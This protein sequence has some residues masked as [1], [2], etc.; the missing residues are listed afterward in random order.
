[1]EFKNIKPHN[2]LQPYIEKMWV[3]KSSG[4]LP[5]EDLKLVV[6]NGNIKLTY[7]FIN[8]IKAYVNNK[9]I[10]AKEGMV[11][12]TGIVDMPLTLDTEH[13]CYTETIG[14]E[15]NPKGAYR[16]FQFNLSKA[17]NDIIDLKDILG[18]K[19]KQLEV[20]ILNTEMILEKL[21]VIQ[22]FLIQILM[23]SSSDMIFE[24]CIDKI[25]STNGM[26]TVK[27]LEKKTGYSTRWLNKKFLQNVG[28]SP[29]NLSSLIRFGECYRALTS[30]DGN[31]MKNEYYN[32]YH[33]QSHFIK[34]FK[35]YTGLLP[36]GFNSHL[37][38]FGQQYYQI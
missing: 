1:M 17:K 11:T 16:F 9:I 19:G 30:K 27:E 10:T 26:I 31:V 13:D 20:K 18:V 24:F 25:I 5:I 29:K 34:N 6:P 35:Q 36:S 14:I 21:K 37:S 7:T 38:D 2:K 28:I 12:V 33:D 15:F 3:F 23:Q 4:K 8:G 32:Y 22:D